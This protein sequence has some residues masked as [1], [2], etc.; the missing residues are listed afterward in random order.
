MFRQS[1]LFDRAA[2]CTRLME[3]ETDEVEKT[4]L[5]PCVNVDCL[6]QM[7]ALQ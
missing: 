7:K 5:G 4:A 3:L 2:E 6:S 1:E